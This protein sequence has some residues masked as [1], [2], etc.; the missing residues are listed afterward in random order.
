MLWEFYKIHTWYKTQRITR[1]KSG[2]FTPR[3]PARSVFFW[4]YRLGMSILCGVNLQQWW[5]CS[6]Y[7]RRS[8]FPFSYV[9]Q[10]SKSKRH[11]NHTPILGVFWRVFPARASKPHYSLRVSSID[12]SQI[13][14]QQHLRRPH[15]KVAS[16]QHRSIPS[17]FQLMCDDDHLP[18][19]SLGSLH[20]NCWWLIELFNDVLEFILQ[21]FEGEISWHSAIINLSWSLL[22]ICMSLM[23][24]RNLAC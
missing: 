6:T 12:L 17:V 20:A 16:Q 2:K 4:K 5:P 1:Y 9:S 23:H 8:K 15:T 24:T 3:L 22:L 13:H 11:A 18:T 19:L 7:H 10:Q 14:S 21:N